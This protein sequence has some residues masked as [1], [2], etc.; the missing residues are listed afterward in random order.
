MVAG[1]VV[2]V[3][4]DEVGRAARFMAHHEHV[5]LHRA[6]VVHRVEQRFPLVEEVATLEVDHVCRKPPGC[7]LEGRAGA[8]G[9]LEE[10]V[11][12]ALATAG[13]VAFDLALGDL[14]EGLGG[15]EDGRQDALGQTVERAGAA[16]RRVR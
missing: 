10:D 9:V 15:V 16:V 4:G 2:Q 8:G 7:D 6:Q 5:G 14:G 12:D 11:E 13:T 1:G 3:V